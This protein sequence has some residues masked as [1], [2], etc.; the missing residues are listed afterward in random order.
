MTRLE[1][2]KRKLAARTGKPGFEENVV[3][4]RAE[5]ARLEKEANDE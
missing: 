5:I 2:L 1:D 3:A 4:I